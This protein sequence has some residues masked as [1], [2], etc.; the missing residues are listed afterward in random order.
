[1]PSYKA[2]II[3]VGHMANK[4]TQGLLKS[5]VFVLKTILE[6][7]DISV[8]TTDVT[9]VNS[10]NLPLTAVLSSIVDIPY[11]VADAHAK[12]SGYSRTSLRYK[13]L[14][15]ISLINMFL[16]ALLAVISAVMVRIGLKGIYRNEVLARIKNCDVVI[17]CSD[18]NFKE[19]A[20]FFSLNFYWMLAW[21]S[22]LF[23]RTWDVLVSK[24]LGKKI[25]LFPN[26]VGPFHTS[27]GKLFSR[28][29]LSKFDYILVREPISLAVV[30]SLKIPS[31]K[32]LT[33]DTA[34]L[35]P[36][37]RGASN[38]DFSAPS[39]GV[40]LGLYSHVL[41]EKEINEYIS[42][43]AQILDEAIQQYNFS[44]VFL[45]HYISGFRYDDLET[46]QLIIEQMKNK[47]RVTLVKTLSVDEF[48]LFLGG[49]KMVISS[50]MHPAVFATSEY[51]PTVCIAYDQKQTGYFDDLGLAE[52]VLSVRNLSPKAF[53]SK[54]SYLW[55]NQAEIAAI[56]REKVPLLKEDVKHSVKLALCSIVEGG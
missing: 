6:N 33:S 55:E 41:T 36:R 18:E 19:T 17:S 47:S 8:S 1:M 56:L 21:W 15:A 34:L 13:L 49:M 45:P 22:M 26:S 31:K 2:H 54:I 20:S 43:Y 39:V 3:H 28:L 25:I 35:L 16:Q 4:G 48:K 29:A 12:K 14:A 10:Q 44:L 53:W 11:E 52:C 46:S 7:V 9:G 51:V 42:L 32:A 30:N 38:K 23:S 37:L 50:K 40:C 24:F 5:D 27:I